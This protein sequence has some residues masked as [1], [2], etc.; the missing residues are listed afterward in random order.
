[1][2]IHMS[3]WQRTLRPA[4]IDCCAVYPPSMARVIPVMLSAASLARK[5]SANASGTD[6]DL[7]A[8]ARANHRR[9]ATL[10]HKLATAVVPDGSKASPSLI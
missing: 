4:V 8:L 1:M 3:D 7:L 6:N 5:R 9:L 10:G 2:A